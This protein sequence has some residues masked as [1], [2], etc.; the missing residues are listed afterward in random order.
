MQHGGPYPATTVPAATS[1]GLTAIKRFM[2]P[3][4]FQNV[5]DALLLDALKDANPLN[6]WRIVD[7]QFTRNPLP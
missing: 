1:V 5:P 3:V 4:A 6:L 2:R 7:G